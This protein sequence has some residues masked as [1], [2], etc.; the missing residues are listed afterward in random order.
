[1]L[2]FLKGFEFWF[3]CCISASVGLM[4]KDGL[5]RLLSSPAI[6]SRDFTVSVGAD[7]KYSADTYHVY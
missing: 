4:T 6:R 5:G 3:R 7:E 1:M 2:C